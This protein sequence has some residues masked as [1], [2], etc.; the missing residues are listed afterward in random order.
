MKKLPNDVKPY[1]RTPL[2]NE[3]NM[4]QGLLKNHNTKSGVWGLLTVQK[5]E[6]E[7]VIAD[8]EI[9]ILSP[10]LSGVIEPEIKHHIKPLG[11]VLFSIE[12]YKK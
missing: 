11:E 8:N 9:N 1:K 4:P 6:I 2:F 5:G 10:Q 3:L 7:Y 12:F